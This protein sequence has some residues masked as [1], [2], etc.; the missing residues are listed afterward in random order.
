LKDTQKCIVQ[1]AR[2]VLREFEAADWVAVHEYGSDPQVVRFMD[3]GPNTEEETLR[4]IQKSIGYQMEKPRIHY[5]LAVVVRDKSR[6]IGGCGVYVSNIDSREGWIGYC[7]NRQ[8]WGQGYAT[9][10]ARALLEFGFNNLNLHRIFATCDPANIASA[11]I[12]EKIGMQYE[13]HLRENV[14][15]KG[16]WHDEL[17]YAILEEE[18]KTNYDIDEVKKRGVWKVN[19]QSGR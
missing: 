7:L 18:W 4:F 16:G 13:G 2:L 5:S 11:H 9:E 10:T 6:L 12:L 1:I 17:L 19:S 3:W 14:Y 8:F 15:C